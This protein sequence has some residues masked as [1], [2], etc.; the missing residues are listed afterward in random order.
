MEELN[1]IYL[2]L[3][4]DLGD[5]ILNLNKAVQSLQEKAG[6]I[7][8]IS[9]VYESAPLGFDSETKF[10][11]ICLELQTQLSPIDL[12]NQLKEIENSQGR[13]TKSIDEIY[14]SR[15]IDIDILFYNNQ[16]IGTKD[17]SIPHRLFKK[18]NFVLLPLEEIAPY[19]IDPSTHLTI[20]QLLKNSPDQSCVSKISSTITI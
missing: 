9:S 2:S 15:I 4:S 5:K 18:R 11:N 16:K 20:R 17:L 7:T 14:S 8:S 10:Y 12:L 1:L 6:R 3:G 13:K 19:L